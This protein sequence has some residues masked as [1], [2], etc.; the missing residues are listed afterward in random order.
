MIV[1]I[2]AGMP[3]VCLVCLCHSLQSPNTHTLYVICNNQPTNQPMLT[4]S[5]SY[6]HKV[7]TQTHTNTHKSA[8]ALSLSP[9]LFEP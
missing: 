4:R 6:T 3:S 9:L 2:R 8:A 7:E 1:W 5:Y